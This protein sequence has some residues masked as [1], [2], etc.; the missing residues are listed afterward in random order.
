MPRKLND[1]LATIEKERVHSLSN[2]SSEIAREIN[3]Y[4]QELISPAKQENQQ[5]VSAGDLPEQDNQTD[6]HLVKP[7]NIKLSLVALANQLDTKPTTSGGDN[8]EGTLNSQD[9]H[10][11]T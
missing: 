10:A 7:V 11:L 6:R 8:Q 4:N 1:D 3:A 9:L 5:K 2:E